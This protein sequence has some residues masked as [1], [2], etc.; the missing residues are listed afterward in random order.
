[1]SRV[2]FTT[3]REAAYMIEDGALFGTCGFMMT[4]AAEEI[5]LEMENR[6][7]ETGKPRNLGVMWASGVGDGGTVRGLNHLCHEG[8]LT[9][10]IGGHYGLIKRMNPMVI[11]NKLEAYNLPQGVMCQMFRDMAARKPG[12]LSHVGLGTFVDPDFQGGKLNEV[13]TRDIVRKIK[14][15]EKDYLFYEAQ[16]LDYAIIRGTEAD[17]NGNISLRKEA[18][19][20]ESLAVAMAARNNGGKVIVQVEKIV[21]NG[22][23]APKDVKI[24]G[25]LVDVVAVTKDMKNHMQTAGTHYNEDFISGMGYFEEQLNEFP[26][27]AR[28]IIARRC[29]MEVNSTHNVLNYGIGVPEGVAAVLKEEGVAKY[30]TASVEPGIVGGIAQGGLNFGSA[31]A[32]EAIIDEPYQFDFYDGGGIDVTFLGMA[33]CDRNANLNVSKFGPRLAGCGGFIDISQNAKNVVFCGTFTAGELDLKVVDG[34]LVIVSEGKS[35]KFIDKVDQITFNGEYERAKGGR[36]I[37]YVTERAVLEL[38]PEGLTLTEIAP[39]VDLQKDILDQMEF[40]PIVSDSLK[41]MDPCIFK[42]CQMDLKARMA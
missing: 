5:F 2:K 3:T 31:I 17:E 36:K 39:G 37:L 19:T 4:G 40:R 8:L 23:I 1:M 12:T 16:K 34:N 35:R 7:L 32:P 13:T 15:D 38:K 9:K 6:F 14:I 24:P 28:K 30:F 18:L 20:L 22:T 21:K 33:Q 10:L 26:L 42:D 25:I 29:A 11:E 41:V 27:D